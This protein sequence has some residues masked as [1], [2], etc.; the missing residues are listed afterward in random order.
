METTA[1]VDLALRDVARRYPHLQPGY[2]RGRKYDP[3]SDADMRDLGTPSYKLSDPFGSVQIS[4]DGRNHPER[5][6]R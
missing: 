2:K 6:E 1:D 4:D 3:K 5:S